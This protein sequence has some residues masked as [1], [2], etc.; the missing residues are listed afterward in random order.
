MPYLLREYDSLPHTNE[1]EKQFQTSLNTFL[2]CSIIS[3]GLGAPWN[4]HF[5]D[6]L[7]IPGKDKIQVLSQY[8]SQKAHMLYNTF[9]FPCKM[10]KYN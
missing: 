10:G 6:H 8:Q 5:D 3:T 1:K 2:A 7:C 9:F 4:L